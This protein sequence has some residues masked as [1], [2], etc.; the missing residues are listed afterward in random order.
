[1]GNRLQTGLGDMAA[2]VADPAGLVFRVVRFLEIIRAWLLLPPAENWGHPGSHSRCT[3]NVSPMK[4]Q[5][6]QALPS[7]I[8]PGVWAATPWSAWTSP[9]GRP[10]TAES[11]GRTGSWG[12]AASI[13]IFTDKGKA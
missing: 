10:S 7:K 5:V 8:S 9:S 6:T 1:M 12:P 13:Y 3:H 2:G 11:Q 4:T